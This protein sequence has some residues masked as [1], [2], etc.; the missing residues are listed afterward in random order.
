MVTKD[1]NIF[2]P[3]AFKNIPKLWFGNNPSGNPAEASFYF[4]RIAKC[5]MPQ[6]FCEQ[7]F[8]DQDE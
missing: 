6:T 4:A 5:N 7:D 1:I 8:L 2:H 3:E